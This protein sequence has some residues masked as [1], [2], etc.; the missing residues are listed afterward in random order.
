MK[1]ISELQGVS[2][3]EISVRRLAI[4]IQIQIQCCL[5]YG[6][7][8]CSMPPNTSVHTPP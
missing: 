8:Q 7:T 2:I 3:A 1:I 4:I 5:Q 6:I